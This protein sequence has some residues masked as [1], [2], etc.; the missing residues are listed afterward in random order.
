MRS[1]LAVVVLVGILVGCGSGPTAVDRRATAVSIP[2]GTLTAPTAVTLPATPA[3]VS[4]PEASSARGWHMP[5]G[6]S[7][8]RDGQIFSVNLADGSS[9]ARGPAPP[10]GAVRAHGDVWYWITDTGIAASRDERTSPELILPWASFAAQF[11]EYHTFATTL[12]LR[13][14]QRVLFFDASYLSPGGA[15]CSVF[16]L[17]IVTRAVTSH[18]LG[19][20]VVR[21]TSIAP[22][23]ATDGSYALANRRTMPDPPGVWIES[24]FLFQQQRHDGG[25]I[26]NPAGLLDAVWLADG[27][28]I[29]AVDAGAPD[30]PPALTADA[31]RIILADAQGATLHTLATDVVAAHLALAPDEQHLAYITLDDAVDAPDASGANTS[32]ELWLS[33]LDGRGARKV[34]TLPAQIEALRWEP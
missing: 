10:P 23:L 26:L 27:R 11:P 31:R 18:D 7:Y 12:T 1:P 21:L 16:A 15:V 34:A 20:G 13:A 17:T 29:Y 28:F 22:V 4:S 30:L 2:S 32:A 8:T 19:C 6:L 5:S 25:Q 24:T 9:L 14:D 3:P 33:T